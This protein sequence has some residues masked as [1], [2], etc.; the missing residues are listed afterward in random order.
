[1]PELTWM[2]AVALLAAGLTAAAMRGRGRTPDRANL[3]ELAMRC[4]GA[5]KA[6]P[7]GADGVAWPVAEKQ[8]EITAEFVAF[9]IM[10]THHEGPVQNRKDAYRRGIATTLVWHGHDPEQAPTG[11]LHN[12]LHKKSFA[13]E[14]DRG[15][16]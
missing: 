4:R 12:I 15:D 10:Y 11:R 7:S 8:I 16:P 2:L 3:R 9:V 1:M 5:E 14:D 13:E 6:L